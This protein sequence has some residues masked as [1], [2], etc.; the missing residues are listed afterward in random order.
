ML[1]EPDGRTTGTVG[2]GEIED[3]VR[4]AARDLLGG[5]D[6]TR[7]L[8]LPAR[9]GGVATVLLERFSGPDRLVVVGA[10]H[11]GRAIAE[12]AC[13]AGFAV[14]VIDRGGADS[15]AGQAI[16]RVA[17]ADP[18]ALASLPEPPAT[19]VVIATGAQDA[20]VAWAIAALR[21]GFA[22]VGVIGSRSKAAAIAAAAER[23]GLT[24]RLPVVRCPVGL[25]LGAVTPAEI[26]VS[27]VAE[28]VLMA[29][30][31]E[32]PPSWRRPSQG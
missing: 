19:Q 10:G 28:L 24:A 14:T 23:E 11:V 22:G 1:L 12:A 21:A 25:D 5:G 8:E 3:A 7:S 31:G 9:C 18:D 16:T 6:A 15:L 32:V 29:H 2:G 13:R 17:A 27:V 20:D 26:A 30:R 4:A